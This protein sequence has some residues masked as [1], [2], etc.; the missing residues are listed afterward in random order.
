MHNSHSSSLKI[1]CRV[2]L[3]I[4]SAEKPW[5]PAQRW[6]GLSEIWNNNSR[7]N[8]L[9]WRIAFVKHSNKMWLSLQAKY[10]QVW[11][12]LWYLDL[13]L[14]IIFL[15][16]METLDGW[17]SGPASIWQIRATSNG[18]VLYPVL[19]I[20]G[21]QGVCGCETAFHTLANLIFWKP[22]GV[23]PDFLKWGNLPS[24]NTA[25]SQRVW[26]NKEAGFK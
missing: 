5:D 6:R 21:R 4:R 24:W 11:S 12:E 20:E 15:T 18:L 10:P 8:F 16:E 2:F 13:N 22:S 14:N 25:P 19:Q 9:Q 3:R 23:F 7:R 26:K 17:Q 1:E